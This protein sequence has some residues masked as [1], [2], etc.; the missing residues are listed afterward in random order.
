MG[1]TWATTQTLLLRNET[2]HK[3]Q[4]RHSKL[5]GK[6]A[7]LVICSDYRPLK[8]DSVLH[9]H[10]LLSTHRRKSALRYL[11]GRKKEKRL[12]RTAVEISD[13]RNQKGVRL[14][15]VVV[16][17]LSVKSILVLGFT[18]SVKEPI[19][20]KKSKFLTAERN[21]RRSVVKVIPED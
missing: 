4:L 10:F 21:L 1:A 16:L 3:R 2:K 14:L 7:T 6:R 13:Q 9:V 12:E 17:P 8:H 5:V 15:V 11:G 19:S 18:R 20:V